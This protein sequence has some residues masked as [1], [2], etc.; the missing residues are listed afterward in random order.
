MVSIWIHHIQFDDVFHQKHRATERGGY[1]VEVKIFNNNFKKVFPT[2]HVN[3]I[4]I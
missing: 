4:S 3:I 2:C 1:R